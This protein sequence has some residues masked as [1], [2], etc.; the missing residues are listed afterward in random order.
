MGIRRTGS[1][2]TVHYGTIFRPKSVKFQS[3]SQRGSSLR[4]WVG[5]VV[6]IATDAGGAFPITTWDSSFVKSAPAD[7]WA[8][9]AA[10]YTEYRVHGIKFVGVGHPLYAS[11]A[12][13]AAVTNTCFVSSRYLQGA[14]PSSVSDMVDSDQHVAHGVSAGDNQLVVMEVT[15]RNFE[16]G[17]LWNPTA[18]SIPSTNAFSL[19][20]GCVQ[21][22]GFTAST[23]MIFG[24][25]YID[26]EFRGY[27]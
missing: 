22:G 17:L 15:N 23:S 18:N 14:T 1:A 3:P 24:V 5:V 11:V 26:V 20:V 2:F 6:A 27:R 19:N 21:A 7:D 25:V 12:G 10:L 13:T 8:N 16:N 9:L 4:R